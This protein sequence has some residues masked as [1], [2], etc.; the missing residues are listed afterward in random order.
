MRYRV[1]GDLK[2]IAKLPRK[3]KN[4]LVARIKVMSGLDIAEKRKPQDGGIKLN[5]GD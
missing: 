3:L 2:N 4:S 5:M 1:D